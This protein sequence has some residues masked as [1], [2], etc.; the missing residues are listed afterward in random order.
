M[1]VLWTAGTG[2][3]RRPS[4]VERAGHS[5]TTA[6]AI[7]PSGA[8]TAAPAAATSASALTVRRP[9]DKLKALEGNAY[10]SH[11]SRKG[12]VATATSVRRRSTVARIAPRWLSN[13]RCR[14]R[15]GSISPMSTKTFECVATSGVAR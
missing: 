10:D 1:R 6:P 7:G 8:A 14:N 11:S 3:V 4:N 13:S 9:T 15:R 5:L 2:S 12:I